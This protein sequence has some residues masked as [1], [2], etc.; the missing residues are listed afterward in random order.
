MECRVCGKT[1]DPDDRFCSN[2]GTALV[3][4]QPQGRFRPL[5][6][7]T[8]DPASAFASYVR[9]FLIAGLLFCLGLVAV[10]GIISLIGNLLQ[11]K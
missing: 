1:L 11:S 10:A 9:P 8:Q 6:Q 7:K 3:E 5:F 4:E 2:C